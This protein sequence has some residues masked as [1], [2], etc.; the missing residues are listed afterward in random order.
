MT[1]SKVPEDLRYT[2]EHEWIEKIG[3]TAVRIGITDFAQDAL[4]DVVFVQLPDSGAEV[5][6]GESFA[7]VESTKSVSD[8]F[9]PLTG[10]VSAVND[11]LDAS[12]ELVNSDPYGEGWLVEIEAAD[13]ATLDEQL[14]DVLD[15]AG[16][17]AV[18]EG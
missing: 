7:E 9:G 10:T 15:A 5:T 3:P 2:A 13:E 17:R 16:Y 1:D 12:P 18:I 11:A 4:G 8:I 6:V 14:G